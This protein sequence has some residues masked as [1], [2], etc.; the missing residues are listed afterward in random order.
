MQTAAGSNNL[1]RDQLVYPIEDLTLKSAISLIHLLS[2]QNPPAQEWFLGCIKALTGLSRKM[3]SSPS[4]LICW[5]CG[6]T[7]HRKLNCPLIE[8][9]YCGRKGHTKR[10]CLLY[11]LSKMDQSEK[12][13][14]R[15]GWRSSAPYGAPTSQ[16]MSGKP[17][18]TDKPAHGLLE[19]HAP[20][21]KTSN[22]SQNLLESS[23]LLPN[24]DWLPDDQYENE[25]FDA[26]ELEPS[27]E[28]HTD[29]D[30]SSDAADSLKVAPIAQSL[31][32]THYRSSSCCDLSLTQED[33]QAH[34]QP[35]THQQ[36]NPG[37]SF[38]SFSPLNNLKCEN[39]STKQISTLVELPCNKNLCYSCIKTTTKTTEIE[40]DNV[41]IDILFEFSCPYCHVIHELDPI[42]G[43]QLYQLDV[44]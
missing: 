20:A 35:T 24:P 41:V 17:E 29:V 25:E 15:S 37:L 2:R 19:S 11:R 36:M 10:V 39:C 44:T 22:P 40:E 31:K 26:N 14:K 23:K 38:R 4:P 16:T 8:C 3:P 12:A 13:K 42:I 9:F 32:R 21:V 6:S 1:L 27:V 43:M 18:P 34:Y 7:G 30:I 28:E 33:T 5:S